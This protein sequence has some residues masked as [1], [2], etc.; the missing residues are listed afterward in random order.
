MVGSKCF[1]FLTIADAK[2]RIFFFYNL[3]ISLLL[4]F[5]GSFFL[6]EI[7]FPWSFCIFAVLCLYFGFIFFCFILF[8]AFGF[9]FLVFFVTVV[10]A[11]FFSKFMFCHF[12]WDF[13]SAVSFS[14]LTWSLLFWKATYEQPQTCKM[15]NAIT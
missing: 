5:L 13:S 1:N 8:F 10:S 4:F 3:C 2:E 9:L 15:Q 11:I 7:S 6:K 12:D 14:P